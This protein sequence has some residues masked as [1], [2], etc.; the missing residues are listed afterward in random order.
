MKLSPPITPIPSPCNTICYT[1]VYNPVPVFELYRYQQQ[2]HVWEGQPTDDDD[3]G[4]RRR[5]RGRDRTGG[6][7]D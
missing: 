6:V 5:D 7:T 2:G 1:Y 3:G 4:W